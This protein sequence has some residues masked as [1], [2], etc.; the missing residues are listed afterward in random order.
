MGAADFVWLTA[1]CARTYCSRS[2]P[3]KALPETKSCTMERDLSI[4]ES[5]HAPPSPWAFFAC[6]GKGY[7]VPLERVDEI[8]PPQPLTRI[9]GC[10]P[11]VCGLIGLR[12]R[13]ITVFDLGVLTGVSAAAAHPDYRVV[14]MWRGERV[15]GL[16]VDEMI[17]IAS[18]EEAEDMEAAR[19]G[20]ADA[21]NRAVKIGGREFTILDPDGLFATLL[22]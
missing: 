12:G 9:P 3:V 18:P 17:T 8:V 1:S 14:L 2:L 7:A 15:L 20:G 4:G 22:T 10:G 5:A 13:V 19:D 6:S 21:A 16:A 11:S